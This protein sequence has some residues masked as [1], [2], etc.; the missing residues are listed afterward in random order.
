MNKEIKMKI[1]DVVNI[2][3]SDGAKGYVIIKDAEG[4]ILV[5]KSNMI[6]QE[7]K[8][9]LYHLFMKNTFSGVAVSSELDWFNNSNVTIKKLR[10]S[11]RNEETS[12]F[13]KYSALPRD[14]SIEYNI[15]SKNINAMII[16]GHPCVKITQSV[17]PDRS[18]LADLTHLS[19][20]ELL[21]GDDS[22]TTEDLFSRI[23]FDK[24]PLNASSTFIL[25]YYIYF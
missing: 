19:C 4:N 10:F 18:L 17:T 7:G 8:F 6:V 20:L 3:D 25:D 12:Y 13:T 11:D 14:K 21:L 16:E 22:A 15:D 23:V 5:S 24:I 9:Y 1:N 2:S